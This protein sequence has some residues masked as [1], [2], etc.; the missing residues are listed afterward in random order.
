LGSDELIKKELIEKLNLTYIVKC[1]G[2]DERFADKNDIIIFLYDN[3]EF[4]FK[5]VIKNSI[6]SLNSG[7]MG[8]YNN[9][10]H[11]YKMYNKFV[12]LVKE[13]NYLG[14]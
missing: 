13:L 3:L 8:E 7:K 5:Y 14:R 10:E 1:P 9:T 2:S 11:F 12:Q 4:E 6:F